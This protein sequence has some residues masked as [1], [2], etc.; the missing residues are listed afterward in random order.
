VPS[1][2]VGEEG[3]GK[4]TLA[5]W[6]IARATH[7]ELDGDLEDKP[8]RV[9]VIGDEDAF[10]PIWVPRLEAAGADLAMLRTLD[11]GE[12]LDDLGKRSDDLAATVRRE[13][14]SLVLLD[15][16]LDHVPGGD[17]GAGIYNPKNV[18]QALMPL[19]R[20]AG[21]Q[22]IAALGLMHPTKASGGSFRQLMAG[23]HQFNAISRSSLLLGE[24]PD[25]EQRR[26][27]VRG[28]GNHSAAPASFEFEIA[29][30]IVWL[31]GYRF[32]VPVVDGEG[33]GERTSRELL[34]KEP[35]AA[36]RMALAEQLAELL[37]EEPQ[38][39][40]SLARAV[41]RASNDGTVRRALELLE[42]RGRAERVAG[43]WCRP[44]GYASATP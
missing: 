2:V 39:Q 12:Y 7:G 17:N 37:T 32:E 31:N 3:T 20:V 26:V 44:S 30:K 22:E 9:L 27:L 25:Y 15:A 1:I 33:E 10:E 38:S 24:D 36:K 14:I 8:I 40:G 6:I 43:G 13:E 4:G 5:A 42:E 21:E 34:G 11:D 16:L 35:K 19:R 41:G 28:K 29:A 23:S 18:R